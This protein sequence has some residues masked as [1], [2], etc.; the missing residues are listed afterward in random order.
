MQVTELQVRRDD[1]RQSR[2][3]AHKAP[4]LGPGE[5]LAQIDQFALTANNV[6]YALSGEMIGYWKYFPVAEEPWGLV[7]VWGFADIVASEHP[8]VPVGRRI[9]GFFPMATHLRLAPAKVSARGFSDGAEHRQALPEIY[10]RY[11]ST[12][13]D[14]PELKALEA[15]RSLLFPLFTTSYVLFDYLV[16]N[17]FFGAK[18]VLIGSASS[19]TGFGLAELL[20]RHARGAVEVVGLTSP[21]NLDFVVGLEVCDRVLPYDQISSLDPGN[22]VVFVDMSGS[23]PVTAAIHQ[24]FGA[25]V[26]SSCS[27]GATHWEEKRHRGPVEGAAPAFFFA[28]AQIAKRETDWGPGEILRRAQA[29]CVRMAQNLRPHLELKFLRGPEAA[30]QALGRMVEGAAAPAEGLLLSLNP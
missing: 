27:V 11:T 23:G 10:N 2:L 30:Q 9:W 28:P 15:E 5:V 8:E 25:N 4:P 16:D 3:L 22:P 6:S 1:F 12:D 13:R 18:Q 19:K 24:H 20:H 14:P 26:R 29:E 7:P 21:R 17:A